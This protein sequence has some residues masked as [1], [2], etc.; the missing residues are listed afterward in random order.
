LLPLLLPLLDEPHALTPMA[1]PSAATPATVAVSL[2]R[3]CSSWG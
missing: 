3:I 2:F 1:R